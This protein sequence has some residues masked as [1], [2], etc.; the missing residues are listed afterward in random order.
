MPGCL[1]ALGVLVPRG[2]NPSLEVCVD[3]ICGRV[4]PKDVYARRTHA[5]IPELGF[6]ILFPGCTTSRC[7]EMLCHVG[8]PRPD[9]VMVFMPSPSE[10]GPRQAFPT[11]VLL[12]VKGVPVTVTSRFKLSEESVVE[13]RNATGDQLLLG[14]TR[15]PFSLNSANPDSQ[16][17]DNGWIY[18]VRCVLTRVCCQVAP[19]CLWLGFRSL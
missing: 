4:M 2:P 18:T 5:L 17:D 6:Q 19:C 16:F 11:E 14:P 3:Q 8:A 1:V 15:S 10:Q 13:L 7:G 12:A 9:L